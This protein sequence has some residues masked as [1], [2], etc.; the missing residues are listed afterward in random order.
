ML[1][2]RQKFD[3]ATKGEWI[4]LVQ[5]AVVKVA[6][7]VTHEKPEE[8]SFGD[9]QD[10]ALAELPEIK[11]AQQKEAHLRRVTLARAVTGT[12]AALA[13]SA[14]RAAMLLVAAMAEDVGKV[15]AG[16]GEQVAALMAGFLVA[17]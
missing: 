12:R 3:L 7:D 1:S 6:S 11:A 2:L 15:N 10:A 9:V 14:Q 8:I 4:A 13:E 16:Q 17:G 5:A